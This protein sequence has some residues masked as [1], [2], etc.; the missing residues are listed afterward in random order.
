MDALQMTLEGFEREVEDVDRRIK[1]QVRAF[2]TEFELLH[3]KEENGETV[4]IIKAVDG[5]VIL[6]WKNNK[7]KK[8]KEDN[9]PH[10]PYWYRRIYFHYRHEK[11]REARGQKGTYRDIYIGVKLKKEERQRYATVKTGKGTYLYHQDQAN[12]KRYQFYEREFQ[13]LHKERLALTKETGRIRKA[14]AARNNRKK[15][16]GGWL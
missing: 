14:I 6:K 2:L 13:A 3:Q 5:A 10:G 4:D 16:A 7:S 12:W 15:K 11:T 9:M 8:R 1:N